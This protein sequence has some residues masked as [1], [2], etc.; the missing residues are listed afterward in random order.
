MSA[1]GTTHPKASIAVATRL[2]SD[3]SMPEPSNAEQ[4]AKMALCP[5]ENGP[6]D[7]HRAEDVRKSV[8]SAVAQKR[9]ALPCH[10]ISLPK[11]TFIQSASTGAPFLQIQHES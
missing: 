6:K 10:Q 4:H 2:K 11:E 3:L 8:L 9:P 7:G 1:T 5:S